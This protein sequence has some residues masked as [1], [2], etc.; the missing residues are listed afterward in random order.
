MMSI[1]LSRRQ[2]ESLGWNNPANREFIRAAFYLGIGTIEISSMVK[3]P[4]SE[5]D[6]A[7]AVEAALALG[8]DSSDVVI[9][10]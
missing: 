1:A 10:L 7:S 2:A 5:E 3:N 6:R 9:V 4:S 8:L